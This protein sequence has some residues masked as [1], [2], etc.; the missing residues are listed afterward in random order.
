MCRCVCARRGGREG[1]TDNCGFPVNLEDLGTFQR[2]KEFSEPQAFLQPLQWDRICLQFSTHMR[3]WKCRG[4]YAEALLHARACVGGCEQH[5]CVFV[6]GDPPTHLQIHT[7]KI[8]LAGK[9]PKLTTS[10]MPRSV[11]VRLLSKVS[12]PLP[13]GKN[14]YVTEKKRVPGLCR[15][16]LASLSEIVHLIQFMWSAQFMCER[17][18][19]MK[20][21]SYEMDVL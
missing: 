5:A 15:E 20:A 2:L 21:S 19:E 4:A 7:L 13:R 8:E 11:R 12:Q 14:R 17:R 18:D 3:L 9:R 6:S 16:R 10:H 1:N